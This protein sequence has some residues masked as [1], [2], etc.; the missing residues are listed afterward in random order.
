[1]G[2]LGWWIPNLMVPLLCLEG[3]KQ[4]E[5]KWRNWEVFCFNGITS[6]NNLVMPNKAKEN[7]INIL[8]IIRFI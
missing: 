1:L 2:L 5:E 4:D 7:D 8:I 6:S 3:T